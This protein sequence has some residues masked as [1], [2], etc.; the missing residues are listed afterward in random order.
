MDREGSETSAGSWGSVVADAAGLRRLE[1]R[2]RV[3][4]A[5]M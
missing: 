1:E 3:Q 2:S 5:A 4:L